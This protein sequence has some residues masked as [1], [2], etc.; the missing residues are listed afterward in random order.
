MMREREEK[1]RRRLVLLVDRKTPSPGQ[2]QSARAPADVVI[3]T[4]KLMKKNSEP[5][6]KK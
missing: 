1:K 2:R 4:R 6:L 3:T 5:D